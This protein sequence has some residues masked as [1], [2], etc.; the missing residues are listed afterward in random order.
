MSDKIDDR[1]RQQIEDECEERAR[2]RIDEVFG[3]HNLISELL[4]DLD[5]TEW[6][7][8]MDR[9]ARLVERPSEAGACGLVFSLR[10]YSY[11]RA[12]AKERSSAGLL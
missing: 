4:Q 8:L 10:Q 9:I 5:T 3:D 7:E 2:S 1:E 11:R 6:Q 12:L